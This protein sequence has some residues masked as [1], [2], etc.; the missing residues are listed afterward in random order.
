MANRTQIVTNGRHP[1]KFHRGNVK[2]RRVDSIGLQ[3]RERNRQAPVAFPIQSIHT[4][5]IEWGN[6]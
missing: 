4:M 1:Q 2:H 6:S 3:R 5:H